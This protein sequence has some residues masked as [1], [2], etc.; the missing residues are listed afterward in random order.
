MD[1]EYGVDGGF[2]E[3]VGGD[4]GGGGVGDD[5]DDGV[6]ETSPLTAAVGSDRV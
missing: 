4:C 6:E 1:E 2:E 3:D 5:R